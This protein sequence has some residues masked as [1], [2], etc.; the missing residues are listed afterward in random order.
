MVL[1]RGCSTFIER[2]NH[3][4]FLDS[5]KEVIGRGPNL[6]DQVILSTP[7]RRLLGWGVFNPNSIYRVRVLQTLTDCQTHTF[8][9]LNYTSVFEVR[10][11]EALELRKTLQLPNAET[12]VFRLVNSDGDKLSGVIVDVLNDVAVVHSG[13]AWIELHRESLIQIL[14]RLLSISTVVW[15]LRP[16]IR[17]QEGVPDA[18]E[19]VYS[20][21]PEITMESRVCV[22]EN[23]VEFEVKLSGQKTGF[24]SDQREN[25]DFLRRIAKGKEVLDLCCYIGCFGIYAALGGAKSVLGIDSSKS[26]VE[27]ATEN[28]R[29]NGVHET[30]VFQ[31]GDILNTLQVAAHNNEQWGVV[32]LDP[33]KLAFRSTQLQKALARYR[34]LNRAAMKVVKKGGLLLTCSCSGSVTL[35]QFRKTVVEAAENLGFELTILRVTG[36]APDHVFIPSHPEGDYL[37]C[38]TVRVN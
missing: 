6:G 16:V 7:N 23:G 4:V 33:P 1:K 8:A 38:L 13:V 37:K 11:K 14:K 3:L 30:C 26:A 25:R 20:S 22:K 31:C 9:I 34:K 27:L 5:I 28:A 36:A 17:E 18:Q 19:G 12:N 29:R 10:V 2:G 21:D 24:Y 35:E 32:I 15:R